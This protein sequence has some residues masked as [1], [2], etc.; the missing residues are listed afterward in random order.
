MI[1]SFPQKTN[2]LK[3]FIALLGFASFCLSSSQAKPVTVQE[4]G[5]G[6]NHVVE[7]NSSTL[8]NNLW[9]YAGVIDMLVDGKATAGFC[10]DPYHWSS[11][12]PLAYNT[13]SLALA[14]KGWV[15]PMGAA[16]ALQ[17][18]QLWEKYYSPAIDNDTAAGLQ[19]A[20]W[21]LVSG[22][23]SPGSF[24][25]VSADDYGAQ[26]MIDW[27]NSCPKAPAAHLIAVTGP[28]QDYVIPCAAPDVTA[29]FGLLS[30]A[31]GAVV[32][33]RKRALAN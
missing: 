29:T 16:T 33:L 19:I 31:L 25:L 23:V 10:I 15:D 4:T 27:V 26:D 1:S 18:E 3:I 13:E 11:S 20:I 22:S 14:P 28:G 8:G 17:I 12:S 9:V 30:L 7:I 5:V 21:E 6:A 32:F 24:S 2:Q